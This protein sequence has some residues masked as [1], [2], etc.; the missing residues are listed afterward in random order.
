MPFRPQCCDLLLSGLSAHWIN[1][2]PG[3]FRRCFRILRPDGAFIGGLLAGETVQELRISLQLAEAERLGGIGAHVSP[4]VQPQD[5][6]GM[7]TDA[8]FVL[9]TIDVDELTV[10]YFEKSYFS[11]LIPNIFQ[12]NYPNMFALLYDLQ[13]MAESNASSNRSPNLK[14][15]ILIAADCIYKAMFAQENQLFDFF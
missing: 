11:K 3:W 1:D 2:L 10:I 13:L 5:I 14:R 12:I 15:E 9:T 6:V 4:F 7:L 8:G